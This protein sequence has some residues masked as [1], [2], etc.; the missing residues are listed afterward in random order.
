M[1]ACFDHLPRRYGTTLQVAATNCE[2][3]LQKEK[4]TL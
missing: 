2:M 3:T 4:I 1:G